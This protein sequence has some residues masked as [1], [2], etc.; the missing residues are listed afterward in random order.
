MMTIMKALLLLAILDLTGAF[1]YGEVAA[2][3]SMYILINSQEFE[4]WVA[5][6]P[7]YSVPVLI[8]G[9]MGDPQ[10]EVRTELLEAIDVTGH[11]RLQLL[12][13]TK[14]LVIW[15]MADESVFVLRLSDIGKGTWQKKIKASDFTFVAQNAAGPEMFL[16]PTTL[17]NGE[18][19]M[20][21]LSPPTGSERQKIIFEWDNAVISAK[22]RYAL[23]N[24]PYFGIVY[25][26]VKSQLAHY[27]GRLRFSLSGDYP[28][29]LLR[30]LSEVSP[31]KQYEQAAAL[32]RND[33]G[34]R[35]VL[36][37]LPNG[38]ERVAFAYD[39]ARK[40][41]N[42]MIF[43]TKMSVH[44]NGSWLCLSEFDR[45]LALAKGEIVYTGENIF[46]SLPE[47]K[48]KFSWKSH[49]KWEM[50]T[51]E[52]SFLLYRIEDEIWGAD[53]N[54]HGIQNNRLLGKKPY[55]RG[56]HWA[57]RMPQNY[58][59]ATNTA[60]PKKLFPASKSGYFI[61]VPPVLEDQ[62]AVSA[63]HPSLPDSTYEAIDFDKLPPIQKIPRGRVRKSQRT[64]V[65]K[66]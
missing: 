43:E 14:E 49:P 64:L 6:L 28:E 45:D 10:Q 52:N 55:F 44:N 42:S 17:A 22:P 61:T 15:Q 7:D 31:K 35:I 23:D 36:H 62:S 38:Q 58:L 4:K 30:A 5:P 32:T 41:W 20:E 37:S 54:D 60:E 65:P 34:Q 29:Q 48:E 39:F 46:Y 51:I 66:Q 9:M 59:V 1:T 27:C 24:G 50:L 21:I 3:N 47:L 8:F 33:G 63:P 13:E 12:K 16:V 57:I 19:D 56:V 25:D 2:D 26:K 53:I 18:Y 11:R 40:K